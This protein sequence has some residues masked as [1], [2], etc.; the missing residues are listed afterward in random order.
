MIVFL[1]SITSLKL[2]ASLPLKNGWLEDE[3]PSLL[4]FDFQGPMASVGQVESPAK[5]GGEAVMTFF[6]KGSRYGESSHS[7]NG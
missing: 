5:S 2:T 4:K 1:V 7:A 6:P 3:F